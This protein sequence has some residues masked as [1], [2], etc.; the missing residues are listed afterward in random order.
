MP[1]NLNKRL[2]SLEQ[3]QTTIKDDSAMSIEWVLQQ[4]KEVA[5][6]HPNPSA[7]VKALELLG[8][9]LG[10]WGEQTDKDDNSLADFVEAL[11]Q[12]RADRNQPEA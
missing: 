9:H 4:L 1:T 3:Q 11:K 7:R 6:S 10:M 2:A 12:V 8:K 5:L